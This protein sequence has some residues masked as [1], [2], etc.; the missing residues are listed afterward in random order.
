[1]LS[2]HPEYPGIA[3]HTGFDSCLSLYD[4]ITLQAFYTPSRLSAVVQPMEECMQT[5]SWDP[6]PKHQEGCCRSTVVHLLGADEFQA[7]EI[8]WVNSLKWE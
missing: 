2:P 6:G 4:P 7:V 5:T 3:D 1:M 8:Y